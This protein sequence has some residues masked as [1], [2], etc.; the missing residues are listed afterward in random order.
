MITDVD[1][2][3]LRGVEDL[4]ERPHEGAVH[5]HQLLL[6]TDL[7][8]DHHVSQPKRDQNDM[9][10]RSRA[11]KDIKVDQKKTLRPCL[12]SSIHFRAF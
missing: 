4:A 12:T 2:C 7:R 3:D 9:E 5:T 6:V 11:S 8:K 10:V 1:S